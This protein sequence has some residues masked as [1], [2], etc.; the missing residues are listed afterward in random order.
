MRRYGD[1]YRWPTLPKS[2]AAVVESSE[3][4][5][6]VKVSGLRLKK[7]KAL[8]VKKLKV[9]SEPC[10]YQVRRGAIT[11]TVT[12]AELEV[13][14][15][16][17]G[18]QLESGQ[19]AQTGPCWDVGV[20]RLKALRGGKEPPPLGLG[21][22]S[23]DVTLCPRALTGIGWS[24]IPNESLVGFGSLGAKLPAVGG[25]TFFLSGS[26]VIQFRQVRAG[27]YEQRQCQYLG[28]KTSASNVVKELNGLS[29]S[30]LK[31]WGL[32]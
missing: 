16:L 19:I 6:T 28:D 24:G 32:V 17:L 31:T 26:A 14:D 15:V 23:G 22:L 21:G 12:E 25:T 5:E 27:S 4:G 9:P 7:L 29:T 20:K 3:T 2:K 8:K 18:A 1:D 30:E 11:L 13:G 10:V